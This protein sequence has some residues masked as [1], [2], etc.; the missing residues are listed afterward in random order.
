MHGSPERKLDYDHRGKKEK[1]EK[2]KRRDETGW[3]REGKGREHGKYQLGAK[4]RIAERE[5]RQ[6]F[7]EF[8]MQRAK[9]KWNL[10][11]IKLSQGEDCS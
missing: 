11:L 8:L 3:E 6:P 4:V 5:V 7:Q 2:E 1:K 9:G 10:P